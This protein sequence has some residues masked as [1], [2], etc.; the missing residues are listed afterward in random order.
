MLFPYCQ[1][2]FYRSKKKLR[3]ISGLKIYII[4][5]VWSGVTVFLPLINDEFEIMMMLF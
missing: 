5:I 4:A 3:S 2:D 1:T